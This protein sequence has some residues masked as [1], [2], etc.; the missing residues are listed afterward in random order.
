MNVCVQA[1]VCCKCLSVYLCA[2]GCFS[3]YYL[4]LHVLAAYLSHVYLLSTFSTL[5]APYL[6]LSFLLPSFSH[7]SVLCLSNPQCHY[8]CLLLSS[9][10]LFSSTSFLPFFIF[11]LFLFSHP[12]LLCHLRLSLQPTYVIP[13]SLPPSC[14]SPRVSPSL[15]PL[16]ISLPFQLHVPRTANGPLSPTKKRPPDGGDGRP[17]SCRHISC[18]TA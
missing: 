17:G 8:I 18:L 6:S 11:P 13:L 1:C 16:P 4:N 15:S 12:R 3:H 14:A 2:C 7:S 9:Y 10:F 5:F